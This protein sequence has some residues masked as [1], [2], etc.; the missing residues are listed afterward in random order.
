MKVARLV[1]IVA[2]VFSS[3]A[4][5]W[6]VLSDESEIWDAFNSLIGLMGGPMTG[7]FMLGILLN[8]RMQVVRLSGSSSV[9]LPY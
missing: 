8:A 9:L 5:I 3:L 7:L 6:L 1:I 4:A 2:G